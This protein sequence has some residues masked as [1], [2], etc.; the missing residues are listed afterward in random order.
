MRIE[1]HHDVFAAMGPVFTELRGEVSRENA[2]DERTFEYLMV[3]CLIVLSG[4]LCAQHVVE[5][6]S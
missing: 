5:M 3:V 6:L 4:F 1:I 2:Q